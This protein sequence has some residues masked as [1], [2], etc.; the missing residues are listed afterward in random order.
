M[1]EEDKDDKGGGAAAAATENDA[2]PLT[3]EGL[4]PEPEEAGADKASQTATAGKKPDGQAGG[5]D[6]D[7]GKAKGGDREKWDAE[8]QRRDQEHATERR[9]LSDQLA[10]AQQ[11]NERLIERLE[12]AAAPEK[13]SE[14]DADMQE[15]QAAVKAHNEAVESLSEESEPGAIVRAQREAAATSKAILKALL[16]VKSSSGPSAEIA[17]LQEQLKELKDG[18]TQTASDTAYAQRQDRLAKHLAKYDGDAAYGPDLRNEAIRLATEKVVELGY[19]G[20]NPAPEHVALLALENAY[21]DARDARTAK[22]AKGGGGKPKVTADAGT[23]GGAAGAGRPKGR[24]SN[25]EFLRR[26]RGK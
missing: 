6:A 11:I 2:G 20:E 7:K 4:Y 9:A 18:A 14:A 23:G 10:A 21:R 16:K 17:A 22:K 12:K 5:D 3:E 19:T 24:M 1:S 26:F 13:G 15:L 25:R 8:R